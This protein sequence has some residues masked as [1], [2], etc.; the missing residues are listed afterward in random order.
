MV[1]TEHLTEKLDMYEN[2]EECEH[3]FLETHGHSDGGL[4]KRATDNQPPYEVSPSL[5]RAAYCGGKKTARYLHNR[6]KN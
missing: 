5:D 6:F 2:L 4:E 1:F 3:N